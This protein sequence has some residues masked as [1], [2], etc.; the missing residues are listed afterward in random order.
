[1]RERGR[2]QLVN[3]KIAAIIPIFFLIHYLEAKEF[4][5]DKINRS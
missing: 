3:I 2:V 4:D 1:M 5:C